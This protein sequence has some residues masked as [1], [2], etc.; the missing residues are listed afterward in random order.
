MP[1]TFTLGFQRKFVK[2]SQNFSGSPFS[3]EASW[4]VSRGEARGEEE[5]AEQE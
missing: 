4:Y 5:I 3:L 1:F 2:S